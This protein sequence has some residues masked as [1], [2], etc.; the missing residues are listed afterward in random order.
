MHLEIFSGWSKTV[1]RNEFFVLIY[2]PC[3]F[4]ETLPSH[5]PLL[6][7]IESERL[8]STISFLPENA[9]LSKQYI[10]TTDEL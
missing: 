2:Y 10:H 7:I 3:V 5:S 9:Q 8:D 1:R 6:I 4:D